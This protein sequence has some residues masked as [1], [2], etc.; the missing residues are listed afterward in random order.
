MSSSKW[1]FSS[2]CPT[3]E[4]LLRFRVFFAINL[5]SI[6][7]K[8]NYIFA[9]VNLAIFLVFLALLVSSLY[10]P[11]VKLYSSLILRAL[12]ILLV[13]SY[14]SLALGFLLISIKILRLLYSNYYMH[15]LDYKK[16]ILFASSTQIIVLFIRGFIQLLLYIPKLSSMILEISTL[17]LLSVFPLAVSTCVSINVINA[18][19]KKINSPLLSSDSEDSAHPFASPIELMAQDPKF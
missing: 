19:E 7:N 11:S 15:Y 16:S 18:H 8:I 14:F 10:F 6:N 3:G 9:L 5:V 13:V 2:T 17:I 1:L 12:Q 4:Y